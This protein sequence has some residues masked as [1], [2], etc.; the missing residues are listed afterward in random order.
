MQVDIDYLR[1]LRRQ[2]KLCLGDVA[3]MIGKSRSMIWRY[4]NDRCNMSAATLIL[5][6]ELYQVSL[7]QLTTDKLD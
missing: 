4:E 1:R 5:L 2:R 6:A 3:A 7:D